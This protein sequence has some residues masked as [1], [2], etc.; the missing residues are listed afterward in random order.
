MVVAGIICYLLGSHLVSNRSLC[1]TI[2]TF[3]VVIG[4]RMLDRDLLR[5]GVDLHLL[6]GSPNSFRFMEQ[7]CEC[8]HLLP[9]DI[10]GT[11]I[12]IAV[13]IFELLLTDS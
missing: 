3:V 8:R 13:V 5:N 2:V 4:R 7:S 11:I 10:Q 9:L 12:V 1:I 6:T